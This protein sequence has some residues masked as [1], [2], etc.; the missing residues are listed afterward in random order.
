MAHGRQTDFT[1]DQQKNPDHGRQP[2]I[3][4][5][6]GPGDTDQTATRVHALAL[7]RNPDD[8]KNFQGWT[9][10]LLDLNMLGNATTAYTDYSSSNPA[11]AEILMTEIKKWLALRQSDPGDLD[12]ADVERLATW[13]EQQSQG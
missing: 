7:R 13:V 4:G 1:G 2:D 6:Q 5:R 8:M 10:A 3:D 9:Q 12:P 11:R